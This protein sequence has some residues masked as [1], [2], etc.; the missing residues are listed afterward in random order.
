MAGEKRIG[1][2][3][4]R[5]KKIAGDSG[6]KRESSAENVWE[7]YFSGTISNQ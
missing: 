7:I 4:K 6:G 2:R 5:N 1:I 3:I